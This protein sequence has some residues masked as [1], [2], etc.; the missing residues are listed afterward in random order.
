MRK[1]GNIFV[2]G[3]KAEGIENFCNLI[4]KLNM[5][6]EIFSFHICEL[7]KF[8]LE[9]Q[10]LEG[11]YVVLM[12]NPALRSFEMWKIMLCEGFEW[13]DDFELALL[14]EQ[15]RFYGAEHRKLYTSIYDF[16]YWR[17]SLY[18]ERIISLKKNL[19]E[20]KFS[21]NV[22]CL[23]LDEF[24]DEVK[25]IKTLNS[26]LSLNSENK[27]I[28]KNFNISHLKITKKKIPYNPKI[29]YIARAI[30]EETKQKLNFELHFL[31]FIMNMNILFGRKIENHH[32]L[33][34]FLKF[35]FRKEVERLSEILKKDLLKIWEI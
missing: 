32:W 6:S 11:K 1:N 25:L 33:I 27:K 34:D 26:F 15:T 19:G 30:L 21:E 9:T 7:N 4:K 3:T 20:K 35:A 31:K 24:E 28:I 10:V 12:R 29:Q 14:R 13:I 16:L 17:S 18:S 5:N 23:I 22:L 8:L 2:F